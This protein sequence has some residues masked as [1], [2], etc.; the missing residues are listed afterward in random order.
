MPVF[1]PKRP[2]PSYTVALSLTP[3]FNVIA[4]TKAWDYF[5]IPRNIGFVLI[6]LTIT[7]VFDVS[8]EN[9]RSCWEMSSPDSAVR[10]GSS[11]AMVR[12]QIQVDRDE[13]DR[14]RESYAEK[15][16]QADALTEMN[17]EVR[18]YAD[19]MNRVVVLII[20]LLIIM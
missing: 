13:L 8:L 17:E 10:S 20:I 5:D 6:T 11:L 2:E 15:C 16:Q 1:Y 7:K 19:S 9:L 14:L 3:S 12:R 4:L 18:R